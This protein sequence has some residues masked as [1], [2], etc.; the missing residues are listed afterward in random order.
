MARGGGFLKVAAA[1][2]V[3]A[4]CGAGIAELRNGNP[5]KALRN[6]VLGPLLAWAIVRMDRLIWDD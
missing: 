4:V 6:F 1:L 5:A 2:V 3:L